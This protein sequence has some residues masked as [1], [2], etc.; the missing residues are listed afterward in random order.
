VLA[1]RGDFHKADSVQ[2][3]ADLVVHWEQDEPEQVKLPVFTPKA[4]AVASVPTPAARSEHSI[5]QVVKPAG[6]AKEKKSATPAAMVDTRREEWI[7]EDVISR[8]VN[9]GAKGLKEP[10]VVAG[11]RHRSP[12][13]DMTEA[14]VLAVLRK[15]KREGRL[16]DSAGRWMMNS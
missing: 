16:R 2:A 13:K 15:L 7:R 4:P 3:L 12:W 6:T 8:L 9:Y 5:V 11:A 14:E 10:I 1:L